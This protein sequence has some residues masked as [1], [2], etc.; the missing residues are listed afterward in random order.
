[1]TTHPKRAPRD[2]SSKPFLRFYHSE[3]LRTKTLAAIEAIEQAEDPTRHSDAL[4]NIAVELMCSA[5]DYFFLGPLK[6]AKV[7]FLVVQSASLGMAG[8]QQVMGAV[9]RNV[10]GRMDAPQLL[11]V[12]GSIRRFMQ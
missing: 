1:M 3:R 7:G 12:C 9:I 4:A 6:L 8:T 11:S 10:I 2:P 5:M